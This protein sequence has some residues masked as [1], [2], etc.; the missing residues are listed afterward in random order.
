MD[1]RSIGL[2]NAIG[3]SSQ[4]EDTLALF[5]NK[6][7]VLAVLP[8]SVPLNQKFLIKSADK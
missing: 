8:G 4:I 7:T 1:V 5:E 3:Q 6:K 2:T